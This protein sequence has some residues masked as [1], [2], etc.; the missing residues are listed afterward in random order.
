MRDPNLAQTA[1]YPVRHCSQLLSTTGTTKNGEPQP[2]MLDR[3][4]EAS[5][6]IRGCAL[7]D[8]QSGYG[9]AAVLTAVPQA[10]IRFQQC[11]NGARRY[12]TTVHGTH[13][14]QTGRFVKESAAA[15]RAVDLG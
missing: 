13:A 5:K 11:K 7:R 14:P 1:R 6:R 4:A 15:I 8:W 9:S 12:P 2:V 10:Y 3:R